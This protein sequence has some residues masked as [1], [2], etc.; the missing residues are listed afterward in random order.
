M[1]SIKSLIAAASLATLALAG[2]T[3]Q[4][5]ASWTPIEAPVENQ[6]RWVESKHVVRF[7]PNDGALSPG[8]RSRLDAF[9]GLARP[10]YND[11]VY[12]LADEG[13][14]E[15][16]RVGSVREYLLERNIAGRQIAGG[17]AADA[18]PNALTLVIGRYIVIPPSCPNWSKPSA[19]DPNNRTS[20]NFGCATASNLGAMVADPG[21]LVAGK[22]MGPGDGT[23]S[24][25]SV[26]RYRDDT[27]KSLPTDPTRKT[28][29]AAKQ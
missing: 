10:D 27:L 3:T 13:A 2:C 15:T 4:Q 26:Q 28:Q 22:T 25:G 29:D 5:K 1:T 11:R 6:V 16:R 24:A 21:D 14:L 18:G 7:S 9:L 19:G 12:V 17:V 8:E 20:S 23:V